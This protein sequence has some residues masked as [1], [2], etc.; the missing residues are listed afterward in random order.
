LVTRVG[1]VGRH[2]GLIGFMGAGKTTIGREVARLTERPLIDLDEEIVARHGSIAELFRDGE[3]GFRRIEEEVAAEALAADDPSVVVLGGG[4]VMSEKTRARLRT[5]AFTVLLSV[6][7]EVAWERVRSGD[8]PLAQDY[9]SFSRLFRARVPVYLQAADAVASGSAEAVLCEALAIK[10]GRGRFAEAR[11]LVVSTAG[12]CAVIVDER[13]AELGLLPDEEEVHRVP[14]GEAAK[15][16]AAAERLW[17]ELRI[18]RNG[19]VV[20]VGGGCTTDLAGF[21][22]ATYLRGIPWVAV[23]T[24]LVGQVDAAIGG[25]TGIDLPAGKNLVGVFHLP[26]T[27]A[28]DPDVLATLPD[29]ERRQGMAEVVKTGLLAGRPYWS[30]PE[31]EMVRSS[32]AFKAAVVLSDPYERGRRAILNLG[33]TFAHA[34]EAASGYTVTHGD[35]VALGLVAALRLS[36]QPTDVV[37]E[38]LHP[39]PVQ[40]DRERAWAAIKRD[41]KASGGRTRLVL[42]QAPGEPVYGVELPDAEVRSALDG[43]VVG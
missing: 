11:D 42:L 5:R 14:S 8:R 34:L 36:G 43:L 23:P 38:V 25:K 17:R 12:G 32:A 31:E 35:A 13:V 22:A 16:V 4:A 39:K 26:E 27:V 15:S 7:V 3:P 33:H 19:V 6:D 28:I 41:K 24:T 29:R 1:A 37:E 2:L 10:L 20:A 21:V 40:V 9:E 18:G 30:L